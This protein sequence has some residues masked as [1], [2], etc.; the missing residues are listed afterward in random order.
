MMPPL[1]ISG[2]AVPVPLSAVPPGRDVRLVRVGAG[3]GLIAR[4]TAMGLAPGIKLRVLNNSGA[5]PFVVAVHNTRIVLGRG[6]AH[7]ML[8]T[9]I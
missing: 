7:R 6:V 3:R 5:G 8:V 4:L 9:L 2:T 1:P